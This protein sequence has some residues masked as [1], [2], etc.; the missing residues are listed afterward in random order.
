MS[1]GPGA[2][3]MLTAAWVAPMD[4]PIIR[5]GAVVFEGGRVVDVGW[6]TALRWL[7]PDARVEAIGAAVLLP[8]LVN[9]HTHLELSDCAAVP[10]PKEFIDWIRVV[11]AGRR[12][13]NRGPF[14]DGVRQCLRFGVTSVG[15]INQRAEEGRAALANSPLRCVSYGEVIGLAKFR[16]KFESL[17]PK[18]IDP[19]G[20]SE[21]VRV[22]LSPHAPYTVDLPGYQQCLR[23]ARERR[24]PL[25]TH[26]AE[27]PYERDFLER[28]DGPF[29]RLLNELGL[30]AE[31]V[32]T[33]RGGPIEFAHS[34]GLLDYPTLLAHVNYCDDEELDLLARGRASVV[35]CPR[36]HA[37][38]GHPPHRWRDMLARG[39]NVAVGTDS[40]ASSPDLNLVNEL[41][42]IHRI[43]PEITCQNLWEMAT[44]RAARAIEADDAGRLAPGTFADV[45]AFAVRSDDPLREVLETQALPIGVWI[46][47]ERVTTGS[48]QE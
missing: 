21:R 28:H 34:I 18:A 43:A 23:L 1:A 27:Q 38:F 45:V 19:A 48:P 31:P 39:I 40:C 4:R 14:A 44:T 7:Y 17:L 16:S 26:L 6:E 9:A 32:E 46:A 36:T 22:G 10:R 5:D 35:Y 15:D 30:F 47:E 33:F 3:T 29:R 11:A 37:Y 24:L 42:L 41:R 25:A 8:G 12:D 20:A 13:S 2:K